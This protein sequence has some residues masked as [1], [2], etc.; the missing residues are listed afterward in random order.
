MRTQVAVVGAGP[1]GTTIA[2]FLGRFGVETLLLERANQI[3]DYP[4]AVGMD[5]ECLRSMQGIGLHEEILRELVQNV[6]LRFFDRKGRCFADIRPSTKEFGWYRRNIFMQPTLEQTLRA[7]LGRYPHVRLL[8]GH[9]VV[10]LTQD[11][12]G[13]TL[14]VR[15]EDGSPLTVRAEY[16]VAA[17]GGRSPVRELL[18]IPLEGQTHPRKWV[19]IDADND[20]VDAPFTGLHCD[21]RRPYVCAHMPRGYRRW[22]FMLFPGEDSEEMLHPDR[23]RELLSQH[24]AEPDSVRVVRARVYTH[25]SRIASSFVRGRVALAGDAAHLMPPWAGQGLNTGIRDATNLAWKL[26]AIVLDRAEPALLDTY[27]SERRDHAQA[28]ID[29]STTLGRILSPTNRAVGWLRDAGLRAAGRLPGA[30][31]WVLQMKFKPMPFYRRGV[32]LHSADHAGG[33]G[34]GRMFPQPL[35]ELRSGEVQR[36]DDVLGDW[37]S[38][39]GYGQDP[40]GGLTKENRKYLAGLDTRFITIVRSRSVRPENI[41]PGC[42]VVED[43]DGALTGWFE[44]RPGVAVVRPDRYLAA[45]TT[46]EGLNDVVGRIRT[47]LGRSA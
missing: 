40:S 46:A 19:V 12:D 42:T 2:N 30:K 7:G 14:D 13:V 29:L 35:V 21:P 4:R 32:V 34:V 9:E 6:P 31:E 39:I 25:H 26:A 44:G 22:E 5:D 28:M 37:F 43:V 1:V 17:D 27:D 18:G 45:L 47:V 33:P 23:V 24:V 10:G 15:A 3:I 36:L 16:V 38:V 20:P 41:S 8:T 11:P